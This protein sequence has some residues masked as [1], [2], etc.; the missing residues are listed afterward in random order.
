MSTVLSSGF[1]TLFLSSASLLLESIFSRV[2]NSMLL[3]KSAFNGLRTLTVR[4]LSNSPSSQDTVAI[5]KLTHKVE[6]RDVTGG[7]M[8]LFPSRGAPSMEEPEI[9]QQRWGSL[10]HGV[11]NHSVDQDTVPRETAMEKHLSSLP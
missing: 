9:P 3:T 10:L 1:V 2:S 11:S 5:F 4:S 6:A 7:G 8:H